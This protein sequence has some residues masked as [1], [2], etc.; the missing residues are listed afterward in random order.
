MNSSFLKSLIV[1]TL[2]TLPFALFAAERKTISLNGTWD[3]EDF[4]KRRCHSSQLVPQ[5]SCAR[6]GA[7]CPPAFAQVDEF[8]SRMVIQ[9]RVRDGRL[10]KNALVSNAGVSRQERNWFWYR[11][12]FDVP[13][14]ASVATLRI[15]KAQFGAAVWLNGIKIGDHLPCFSGAIFNVSNAVRPGTNELI[16]RVGAHPGVL[17]PNVS[18]GTDFEKIRW[19]PGIYDNV[20]LTLSENPQ[21]KVSRWLQRLPTAPS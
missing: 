11:H 9:N 3:I 7:F 4:E 21:S 17:P 8:D 15:N 20:S 14:I 18:G 13:A 1:L 10:P 12:T 16:V 5:S 2:A 19:T 6:T